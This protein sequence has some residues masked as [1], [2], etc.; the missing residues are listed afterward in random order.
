MERCPICRGSIG[1]EGRCLR[2]G[3]DLEL[4]MQARRRGEALLQQ[5][6]VQILAGHRSEAMESLRRSRLWH[7]RPLAGWLLRLLQDGAAAPD[8]QAMLE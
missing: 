5:A 6:V 8:H 1:E 2:C 3:A 4:V 7:R